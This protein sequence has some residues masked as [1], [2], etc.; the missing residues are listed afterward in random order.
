MVILVDV[1]SGSVPGADVA[2]SMLVL[3]DDVG[4]EK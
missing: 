1:F 2:L 3:N 4:R